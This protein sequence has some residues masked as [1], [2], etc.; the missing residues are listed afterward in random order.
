MGRAGVFY[1]WVLPA[2]WAG[3]ALAQ[4]R[5]PGDENAF[6]VVSSIPALWA[7]LFFFAARVPKESIP[8]LVILAGVPV[9]AGIGW[10]MDRVRVR[11]A[12]WA[13]LWLAIGLAVLY[14]MLRSFPSLERA[15][16]KNGSLWAYILLSASLGLYLS[17]P[18]SMVLTSI[19]RLW[20]RSINTHS[21]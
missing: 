11:K 13:G 15:I 3:C 5:F 20:R 16:S 19:A 8:V 1:I 7:A 9:M 4:Y 18:L 2:L 14:L 12:L 10:V 6:A 17:V 21:A